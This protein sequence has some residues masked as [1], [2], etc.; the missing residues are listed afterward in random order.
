MIN[1]ENYRIQWSNSIERIWNI[2]PISYT[3]IQFSAI[4]THHS[5]RHNV[6]AVSMDCIDYIDR[7]YIANNG[8]EKNTSCFISIGY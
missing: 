3:S 4:A 2:L 1:I 8:A 6:Y 7:Y 5:Q